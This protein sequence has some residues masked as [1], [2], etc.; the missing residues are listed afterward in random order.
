MAQKR[1]VIEI[2]GIAPLVMHNGR[3]ANPRD[4]YAKRLKEISGKRKKVDSDYEDMAQI[5]F[6][7][8]LYLNADSKPCIPA[9]V[10]ESMLVEGAKM[11]RKGK[12][13]KAGIFCPE[14]NYALKYKGPKTVEELW[15]DDRF[16]LEALVRVSTSRIVRTRPQFP[17]WSLTFDVFY[18]DTVLNK[19]DVDSILADAGQF[20]G[21]C[22]WRPRNGRFDVKSIKVAK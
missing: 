16:V 20:V 1:L 8:G 14:Q 2:E 12:A 3:L 17:D 5:E 22:D 7:G 19:K 11:Q 10:I 21:L 4:S 13:V 18:N 9:P 6:E 15:N